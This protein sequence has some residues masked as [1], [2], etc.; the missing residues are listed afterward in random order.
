MEAWGACV[1]GALDM[2]GYIRDLIEAG[3]MEVNILPKDKDGKVESPLLAGIPFSA[4]IT[5]RKPA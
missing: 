1:A 2:R 4:T 5:A 3:F